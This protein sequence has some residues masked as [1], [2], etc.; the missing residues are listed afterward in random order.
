ML[1]CF[2]LAKWNEI[3]A[4]KISS[5]A[6]L[7]K[8]RI[9]IWGYV[10]MRIKNKTLAI[11]LTERWIFYWFQAQLGYKRYFTLSTV[12]IPRDHKGL[13]IAFPA[14]FS[15]RRP[16]LFSVNIIRKPQLFDLTMV[17]SKFKK[18][19]CALSIATWKVVQEEISLAINYRMC[20][21]IEIQ[22]STILGAVLIII[23]WFKWHRGVEDLLSFEYVRHLWLFLKSK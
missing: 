2:H 23:S 3:L 15:S 8:T 5:A 13:P 18:S 1:I 4:A 11:F 14:L 9:I 17:L 22:K 20:S 19:G 10:T 21:K 16:L 6:E 7:N 12:S